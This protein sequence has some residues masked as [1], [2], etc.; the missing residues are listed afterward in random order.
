M[1]L[2]YRILKGPTEIS[3]L[4]M[5]ALNNSQVSQLHGIHNLVSYHREIAVS[6]AYS[7]DGIYLCKEHVCLP[8]M[9]TIEGVFTHLN[10][11]K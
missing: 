3:I 1:G 8:K 6:A 5:E 7:E 11:R 9:K 4:G 10:S 2:Y